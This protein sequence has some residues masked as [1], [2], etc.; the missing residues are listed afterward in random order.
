M[1]WVL[2]YS[3]P[4]A[5]RVGGYEMVDIQNPGRKAHPYLHT[6]AR[7]YYKTPNG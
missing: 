5:L 1:L 6:A 3:G 7:L 4:G 2:A